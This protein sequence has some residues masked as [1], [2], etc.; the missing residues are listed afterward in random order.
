MANPA[1]PTQ[2]DINNIN[3]ALKAQGITSVSAVLD[4]T[5]ANAIS[6]QGSTNFSVS[7]DHAAAGTL[8][9]AA[10]TNTAA[11]GGNPNLA[12]NAVA[13]AIQ[14]LGITQ[15]KVGTGENTLNYAINLAQS[16]ITNFSAAESQIRDA[17]IAA[18]AANLTKA[19]VL[20]Q[21]SI[22]AMAQANSAPQALLKLFQ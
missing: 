22:A 19:Q 2:T 17:N 16:Q 13:A 3:N 5:T 18:E 7:D 9:V 1:A 15:G 20:Q 6:F 21:S 4:Q 14:S 8:R 12:I 10:T 11:A